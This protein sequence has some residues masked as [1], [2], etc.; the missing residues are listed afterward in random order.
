MI[1]QIDRQLCTYDDYFLG[2]IIRTHFVKLDEDQH[3]SALM[4]QLKIVIRTELCKES[5]LIHEIR[6]DI[7]QAKEQNLQHGIEEV[8]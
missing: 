7:V 2:G 1:A 4:L 5:P 8:K 6:D 3:Q